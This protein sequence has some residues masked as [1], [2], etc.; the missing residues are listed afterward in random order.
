MTLAA[1][2]ARIGQNLS[3]R[4]FARSVDHRRPTI[5]GG[6]KTCLPTHVKDPGVGQSDSVRA[7]PAMAE[8]EQ[9]VW[10]I[11]TAQWPD[12]D[13]YQAG[14]KRNIPVVLLTPR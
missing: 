13:K 11:M 14:T 5:L 7:R 1:Q 3:A 9:R 6:T 10:P 2:I 12:Y 4:G 8:E